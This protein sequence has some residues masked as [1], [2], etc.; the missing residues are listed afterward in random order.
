MRDLAWSYSTWKLGY[1]WDLADRVC[2]RRILNFE[3]LRW[4]ILKMF[5]CLHLAGK[6]FEV[7]NKVLTGL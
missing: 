6:I 4:D 2:T 7:R 3:N 1:M 5:T